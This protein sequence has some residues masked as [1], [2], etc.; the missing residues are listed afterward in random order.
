MADLYTNGA[1][2]IEQM[3]AY[4]DEKLPAA[5]AAQIDQLIGEDELFAQALEEVAKAK[6]DAPEQLAQFEN[7]RNA[8][9]QGSQKKVGVSRPLFQ[10]SWTAY[11]IAAVLAILIAFAGFQFLGGPQGPNYDQVLS[12]Y[13]GEMG[14]YEER[15]QVRG[16]ET[17]EAID[18]AISAYKAKSYE[19]AIPLLEN[20][21]SQPDSLSPVTLSE[22]QLCLAVSYW[23]QKS[24]PQADALFTQLAQQA[25]E[26]RQQ[27]TANWYHA[28]SLLQQ[29]NK[30]AAQILLNDLAASSGKHQQAAQTLLEVMKN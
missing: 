24:F 18:R 4:L 25:A 8:M 7:L 14:H 11:A 1:Y 23:Q 22:L 13:T 30:V 3:L 10:Q 17:D 12:E 16:S 27:Q 5:E 26:P 19:T 9:V 2:S 29:D 21:V 6:R 28:L 20:I 15:I